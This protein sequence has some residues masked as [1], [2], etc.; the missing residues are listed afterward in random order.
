MNICFGDGRVE[1]LEPHEVSETIRRHNGMAKDRPNMPTIPDPY[2][3]PF[4]R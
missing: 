2:A 4:E 3:N 1:W